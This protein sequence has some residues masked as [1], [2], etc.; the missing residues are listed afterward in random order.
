M[1]LRL[2]QDN[3]WH[4]DTGEGTK[5]TIAQVYSSQFNSSIMEMRSPFYR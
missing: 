1:L 3:D 4:C 5:S 2:S